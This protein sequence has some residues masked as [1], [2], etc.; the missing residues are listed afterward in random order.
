MYYYYQDQLG[1]TRALLD[2]SGNTVD[3]YAHN[4]YGNLSSSTGSVANPFKYAGQYTDAESGL[5]YLR[6]RYYDPSTQQFLT[7]DPLTAE[8]GQAYSYAGDN[9]VNAVDPSGLCAQYARTVNLSRAQLANARLICK[10]ARHARLSRGRAR[11]MVAAAMMESSLI[12]TT[13]NPL[14]GA[15]GLFQLLAPG[16]LERANKC[17]GPSNPA[18]NTHVILPDYRAYWRLHPHARRGAAAASVEASGEPPTWYELPLHGGNA[19]SLPW[20]QIGSGC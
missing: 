10:I 15:V 18:C 19:Y 2:G 11:E 20:S 8:T 9:P 16:Y 7:V 6:A 5:Q 3:T 13:V 12:A 1:S 17:G 4:P 14:S